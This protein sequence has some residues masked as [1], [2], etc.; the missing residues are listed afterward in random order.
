MPDE[1]R[2]QTPWDDFLAEEDND[3]ESVTGVP[4]EDDQAPADRP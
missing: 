2:D 1:G 4:N 3:P